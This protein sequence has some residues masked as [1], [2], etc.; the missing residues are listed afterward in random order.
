MKCFIKTCSSFSKPFIRLRL[1]LMFSTKNHEPWS[2]KFE[3]DG[4]E[5]NFADLPTCKNEYEHRNVCL[6]MKIYWTTLMVGANDSK[7]RWEIWYPGSI[8]LLVDFAFVISWLSS[9]KRCHEA[10]VAHLKYFIRS[11]F[12][13][14]VC[15]RFSHLEYG[16]RGK[17]KITKD[18]FRFSRIAR[19][20][21]RS[22]GCF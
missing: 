9:F 20:E 1:P 5:L 14:D 2:F 17:W 21:S 12:G 7:S 16:G 15:R 19:N 18:T 11:W 13:W 22:N 10:D 4:T 3:T 6:Y 8:F